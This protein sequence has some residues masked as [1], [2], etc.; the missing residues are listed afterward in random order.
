MA[1]LTFDAIYEQYAPDVFRFALYLSGNRTQAED[2]AAE[3]FAR[4]WIAQDRINVGSVKA[5]LLTIARNLYID[6]TRRQRDVPLPAEY[7]PQA[8]GPNPETVAMA[9]SEWDAVLRALRAMPEEE[10]SILLMASVGGVPYDAIAVAFG[11]STAAVKVRVHRARI[12]LNAA[13][14]SQE[15]T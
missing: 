9:R 11:I 7:D 14:F 13:R 10:R 15:R 6:F 1:E 2:L 3:T 8:A 5:Y 4:A 12:K